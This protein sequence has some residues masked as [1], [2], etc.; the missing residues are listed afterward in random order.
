VKKVL[1]AVC[2]VGFLIWL[3]VWRPS[4]PRQEVIGPEVNGWKVGAC[5]QLHDDDPFSK[6]TVRLK[7][8]DHQ[9]GYIQYRFFHDSLAEWGP[10]RSKPD[11]LAYIYSETVC[12]RSWWQKLVGG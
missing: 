6:E 3:F 7:V 2:L 11:R 5:Y 4:S 8:I 12:P 9:K 1:I 10:L